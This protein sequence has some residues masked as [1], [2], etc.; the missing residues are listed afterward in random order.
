[1]TSAR[2]LSLVDYAAY[3]A[4]CTY[5]S[6]LHNL[7]TVGKRKNARALEKVEPDTFPLREW[8]DALAYLV[9][10]GPQ[11]T[12]ASARELLIDHLFC[13]SDTGNR[14]KTKEETRT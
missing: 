1:M 12:P 5:F 8:N 2:L 10:A 9:R 14:L 6:D 7:D 4:G 3:V 13:A 11:Q